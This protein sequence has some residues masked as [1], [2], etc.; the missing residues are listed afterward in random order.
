MNLA[1]V[2][3][4]NFTRLRDLVRK[5]PY[6]TE[7]NDIIAEAVEALVESADYYGPKAVFFVPSYSLWD[8]LAYWFRPVYPVGSKHL[9]FSEDK[10]S[11]SYA[12]SILTSEPILSLRVFNADEEQKGEY[13]AYVADAI[14]HVPDLR[15]NFLQ[16]Y[17]Q[18]ETADFISG[19][20][21]YDNLFFPY[22]GGQICSF[23][24]LAPD[25][26][27]LLE[28]LPSKAFAEALS[29]FLQLA[30]T[31]DIAYRAIGLQY[32]NISKGPVIVSHTSPFWIR[33]NRGLGVA[34]QSH[35]NIAK[36]INYEDTVVKKRNRRP[37]RFLPD[38]I[39][40][41][42]DNTDSKV[43][44]IFSDLLT[45]MGTEASSFNDL[46][47]ILDDLLEEPSYFYRS[48]AGGKIPT[49][50]RST[51]REE[52]LVP[53]PLSETCCPYLFFAYSQEKLSALGGLERDL[54]VTSLNSHLR[55]YYDQMVEGADRDDL[56][57]YTISLK[58]LKYLHYI[59]QLLDARKASK[60]IGRMVAN[61]VDSFIKLYPR[62]KRL[63]DT[64]IQ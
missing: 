25:S 2:A 26:V 59:I 48:R 8:T 38:L 44:S 36:L 64:L 62:K 29:L 35:G 61:N 32:P 16:L 11:V 30:A 39:Q 41:F 27:P 3:R 53:V 60:N 4:I 31:L 34:I 28:I 6:N 15:I 22:A 5:E 7:I 33:Y 20:E 1:T 42:V 57:A 45:A 10:Y 40:L 50:I 37:Y 12:A 51:S 52:L 23:F 17:Y 24:E 55:R 54:V 21:T 18:L 14:S 56:V 46:L 58:R 9:V 13:E 47:D 43:K 19:R 49:N 63:I